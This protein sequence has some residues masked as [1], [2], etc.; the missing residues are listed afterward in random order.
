MKKPTPKKTSKPLLELQAPLK[1]KV[2]R[3]AFRAF[4]ATRYLDASALKAAKKVTIECGTLE[5]A[6]FSQVVSA[7]IRRGQ[8]V[9]L[10]PVGCKGC[11]PRK[12]KKAGAAALKKSVRLVGQK[13]RDAGILSPTLPTPVVIS[14]RL[15]FEI[16]F[17][18][19]IIVIGD[20]GDGGFDFC[21]QIWI[22]NKLCWWCL[23]SPSGCIGFGPP[24][25]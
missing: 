6:G 18:P 13:L 16:P 8:V 5:F 19:I 23:L 7:E 22:G 24:E 1:V 11:E 3:A 4:E 9:A 20:P 10:L 15:G 14:R 17:G 25:L 21:V 12:G 2:Y